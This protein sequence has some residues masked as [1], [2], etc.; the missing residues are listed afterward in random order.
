MVALKIEGR[1]YIPV[2]LPLKL[3]EET[4]KKPPET[5]DRYGRSPLGASLYIDGGTI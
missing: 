3:S 2:Q 4:Y 5:T 1:L